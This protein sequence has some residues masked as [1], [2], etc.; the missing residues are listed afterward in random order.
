MAQVTPGYAHGVG[1]P[2]RNHINSESAS[3]IGTIIFENV[4]I[5]STLISSEIKCSASNNHKILTR[6]TDETT[7]VKSNANHKVSW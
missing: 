1:R 2:L 6:T 7:K 5:I 4:I 3:Q